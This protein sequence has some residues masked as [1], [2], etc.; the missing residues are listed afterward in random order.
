MNCAIDVKKLVSAAALMLSAGFMANASGDCRNLGPL[1]QGIVPARPEAVENWRSLRFGMFIHWGPVSLSGREIGWS[2]GRQTPV[3]EYDSLYKR[4]NPARFNAD[5]W[6]AA[7]K[8]AGMKYIVLTT[9]H[10]DGFCL[11]N[12]RH[13]DYSIM[14]TPFGRDVV[15]E[16]SEACR[17]GGIRF[18]AYYSTCDWYHPD[19]PLASPGGRKQRERHDLDAYTDYMKSQIHELLVNYGPLICMWHDVPQ[20]F[21]ARRGAGVVNLERAIQPDILVNNR[22]GHRGDFSTP[23]QRIGGFNMQ[24]PWETCMTICRQWAWKPND[25]MKSLAVCVQSLLRTVGGDGNFL[26]N[27]GPQPDGLI[28]PRQ[29]K[30]LKEMGEWIS[31]HSEAI[32]GTRGGPWKPTTLISSTRKGD[33]IYLAVHRQ[34]KKPLSLPAL[35][36]EVKSA[37]TLEGISVKVEKDGDLFTLHMPGEAWDG[38]ATVVELTVDGEAMSIPPIDTVE[39]HAIPGAKASASSVFQNLPKFAAKMA[40]DADSGT[41]WATPPGTRQAW[42]RIDLPKKMTF[43]GLQIDEE[44][45]DEASRVKRWA[46]QKLDGKDWITVYEGKAIGNHFE[47]AVPPFTADAIRI[48]ILDATEGPTFSS[49]RLIDADAEPKK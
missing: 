30:R 32:Y 10:H 44:C 31:R 36:L 1:D 6:V 41:R 28:E 8:D 20:K 7:A 40:I 37:K 39:P 42:L 3:E 49:V 46:L 15:K 16:L 27:V 11:W 29:V 17:R 24:R 13:T 47:T 48:N 34:C 5:E 43:K 45:C 23:E 2:R 33:K 14:N 18:G 38:V 22:T 26:F 21:D 4:F 25:R 19:F 35:P 12:T 9:K